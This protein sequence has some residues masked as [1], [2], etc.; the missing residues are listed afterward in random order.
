MWAKMVEVILKSLCMAED[1]IPNQ[2]W[3]QRGEGC[4]KDP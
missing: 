1:F 3:Q 4:S 2:A